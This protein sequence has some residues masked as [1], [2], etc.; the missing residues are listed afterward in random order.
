[1]FLF[2]KLFGGGVKCELPHSTKDLL[3]HCVKRF[4]QTLVWLLSTLGR[5]TNG[6]HSLLAE[7]LF[8]RTQSYLTATCIFSQSTLLNHFQ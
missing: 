5:V 7:L 8:K 6:D 1:M 2:V 3:Q 4:E